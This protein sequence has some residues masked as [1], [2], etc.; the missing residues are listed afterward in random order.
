MLWHIEFDG[1]FKQTLQKANLK[2][3]QKEALLKAINTV[4]TFENPLDHGGKYHDHWGYRFGKN[5]I[6]HCNIDIKRNV[7]I[8]FGV[9][10]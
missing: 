9:T 8:I 4:A 1:Q 10:F 5:S 3:F 2:P 6:L 7:I